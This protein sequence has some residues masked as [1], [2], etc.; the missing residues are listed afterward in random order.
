MARFVKGDVVVVP[1]P[2]SDLTQSKRRPALVIAELEGDDLILCQV[3]SQPLQDR[4]AIPVRDPDFDVGTLRQPSNIRPNRLFTADARI[5][6]YRLGRLRQDKIVEVIE[7]IVGI[8]SGISVS[9][10]RR[11]SWRP[12]PFQRNAACTSVSLGE[13]S[14]AV[15]QGSPQ[16]GREIWDRHNYSFLVSSVPL[17]MNQ[18]P[19]II[20]PVPIS[21]P[22]QPDCSN[23]TDVHPDFSGFRDGR[24]VSRV[25]ANDI[26]WG[27]QPVGA[28]MLRP[29]LFSRSTDCAAAKGFC[30]DC[31][32]PA[33]V[34]L[35]QLWPEDEKQNGLRR[36]QTSASSVEPSSRRAVP[37]HT[38]SITF[39]QA[40][41][42]AFRNAGGLYVGQAVSHKRLTVFQHYDIATTG[43]T[44]SSPP[45]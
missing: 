33:A 29:S 41:A 14:H 18:R 17:A 16:A 44:F 19:G 7:R 11:V 45:A 28:R 40:G 13:S 39:G 37:S 4:Y 30:A 42:S 43:L 20:E 10:R 1:F 22:L 38:H 24:C 23:K 34:L 9:R 35:L 21:R 26:G 15:R 36:A 27:D 25:H 6:L 32:Q 8:L 12:R 5:V 3:T 2:F 31:A